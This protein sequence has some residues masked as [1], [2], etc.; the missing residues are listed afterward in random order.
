MRFQVQSDKTLYNPRGEHTKLVMVQIFMGLMAVEHATRADWSI[1]P[2]T[3]PGY[4]PPPGKSAPTFEAKNT[5]R[6]AGYVAARLGEY[7]AM[8]INGIRVGVDTA[9]FNSPAYIDPVD[10]REYPSEL[11]MLDTIIDIAS[12]YGMLVNLTCAVPHVPLQITANFL[13]QLANRYKRNGHVAIN[14]SNEINCE[15]GT[16]ACA[17][18]SIWANDLA[19]LIAAIRNTG[20]K[21]L[22][23]L[24]PTGNASPP[25]SSGF[26]MTGILNAIQAAP[27]S[28]DPNLIYGIHYYRYPYSGVQHFDT[29]AFHNSVG[30]FL[31][32]YPM[33][34]EETG[35]HPDPGTTYD[36]A[37]DE[38]G[39]SASFVEW[40]HSKTVWGEALAHF[41]MLM[42]TDKLA[43]VC[44]LGDTFW[45]G[46]KHFDL[47]VRRMDGTWTTAGEIM[48]DKLLNSPAVIPPAPPS[49]ITAMTQPLPI[50]G[51][52][53]VN[54]MD[55]RVIIPGSLFQTDYSKL[56]LTLKA[57]AGS[58]VV[59]SDMFVGQQ[60]SVGEP[61]DTTAM[62]RIKALQGPNVWIAPGAL[63]T[64]DVVDI[65]G[66]AGQSL[67]F[68]FQ[69]SDSTFSAAG[70][71]GLAGYGVAFKSGGNSSIPNAPADYQHDAGYVAFIQKIEVLPA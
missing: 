3:I 71:P 41:R 36:P 33:F 8:G 54:G 48:R 42:D 60:A 29:A 45:T 37:I 57:P 49:Y 68:A 52:G 24:N 39:Q 12:R 35:I 59:F 27:F 34:I 22:I 5:Y 40:E 61:Y 38:T 44:V 15:G 23:I 1:R 7:A 64:V 10:G 50:Q 19:V 26:T 13:T 56:R 63:K 70:G 55:F 14:P 2:S 66:V 31:G 65:A 69:V 62:T 16:A 53:N 17:N 28:T 46:N 21:N 67:V 25:M 47:S 11:E 51:G 58:Q 20:A 6:N 4:T 18:P 32:I 9:I 30:Q 43:G